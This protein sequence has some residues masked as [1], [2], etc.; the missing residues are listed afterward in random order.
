[1]TKPIQIKRED[2]ARDV[3]ILA[4]RSGQSITDAVGQ[5]VRAELAQPERRSGPEAKLAAVRRIVAEYKALPK[6]G[7]TL[8]D[9]DLYDEDGL[10]K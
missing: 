8:T 7:M 9:G 4:A 5:L 10:P 3:R 1:M 6:T 2:V